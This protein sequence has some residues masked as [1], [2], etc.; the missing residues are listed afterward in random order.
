MELLKD[1]RD[2]TGAGMVDCKNALEEANGDLEK[3]VEIL[4]KKGIAKAAKRGDRETKEGVIKIFVSDDQKKAYILEISAETDFV[5]RSEKFQSFTDQV[6]TAMKENELKNLNEL[7]EYKLGEWSV[8]ETLENLSGVIGEKMEIKGADSLSSDGI[9][10]GYSHMNGRIGVLVAIDKDDPELARE[11]AMQIAAASP[12]YISP[13]DV[14]PEE[15]EKEKEIYREQLKMEGK[16]E[17]M[18][19]KIMGGK[20]NK[21]YD[22]VCLLKQECIKDDKKK[23][24]SI[25]NGAK[26]LKFIR[27]SL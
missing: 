17:E 20:V 1:L 9:V 7:L 15:L 6:M 24:E 12:R 23:V 11:L 13:E 3:A 19:E 26:V 18:I 4:R 21:F 5:V 27:Y 8:K 25:L 10:A 2:K 22:E 14:V 16:P